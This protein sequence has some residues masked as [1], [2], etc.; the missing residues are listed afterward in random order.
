MNAFRLLSLILRS[1]G[2]NAE[3]HGRNDV[4]VNGAK[5]SGN[6][7]Y[8]KLKNRIVSHGTILYNVDLTKLS[9]ALNPEKLELNTNQGIQSVRSRVTNV[10]DELIEKWM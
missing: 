10:Y 1:L 3:F 4:H 5:I 7:Q 6:A 8:L 2:L 9:N